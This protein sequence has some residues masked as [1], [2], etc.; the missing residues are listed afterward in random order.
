[1]YPRICVP[2]QWKGWVT[3]PGC[4][5]LL[6][7]LHCIGGC[8]P[9]FLWSSW[10]WPHR[11]DGHPGELFPAWLAA[12]WDLCWN[13]KW[14]NEGMRISWANF[15]IVK[16]EYG[17]SKLFFHKVC[18]KCAQFAQSLHKVCTV[19]TK[20]AQ[21]LHFVR[22]RWLSGTITGFWCKLCANFV[23][24]LCKLCAN[25]VHTVHTVQTCANCVQTMCKLCANN[26]QTSVMWV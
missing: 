13:N 25:Y 17:L 11:D 18:A 21:S 5:A 1:M 22:T 10:C 6:Q 9:S 3:R 2:P 26:V 14:G 12:T 7:M 20:F 8:L 19:C 16:M 15:A 4:C 23:Q 24:T